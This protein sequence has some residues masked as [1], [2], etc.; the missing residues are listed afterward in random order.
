MKKIIKT[1]YI[2]LPLLMIMVFSNCLTDSD[3]TKKQMLVRP[4]FDFQKTYLLRQAPLYFSI[5][6]NVW[7]SV[8]INLMDFDTIQDYKD[9]KQFKV[10]Q[11]IT[12]VGNVFNIDD[13]VNKKQYVLKDE[14][15]DI[16]DKFLTYSISS[17]NK[18]IGLIK[19][20]EENNFLNY[21]L[22]YKDRAFLINGSIKKSED[23]VYGF[24][25]EII[26]KDKNRNLGMIFKEYKYYIN[27][28]E[29]YINREFGIV[30]DPIFIT[31]GVF[32]DQ[33]LR[34]HGYQYK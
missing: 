28:Y 34:D 18:S 4:K 22:D 27:E 2:L 16:S 10:F 21:E 12:L 9:A 30:E 7:K 14:K 5:H 17:N 25:Y 26:D 19:Q 31:L 23:N 29:I 20:A 1:F 11:K 3:E 8:P 32:L 33:V 24:V 6:Y 13:R 15:T